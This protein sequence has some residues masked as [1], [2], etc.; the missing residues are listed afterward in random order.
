[1]NYEVYVSLVAVLF[2]AYCFFD[3]K[4]GEKKKHTA[5]TDKSIMELENN[6][7]DLNKDLVEVKADV[8]R[9]KTLAYSNEKRVDL[10]E[11]KIDNNLGTLTGKLEEFTESIKSQTAEITNLLKKVQDDTHCHS[12]QIA[13]IQSQVEILNKRNVRQINKQ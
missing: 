4:F 9:A 2:S 1:M 10:L 5:E 3:A 13:V 7:E 6:I 8:L 11:V 12:T